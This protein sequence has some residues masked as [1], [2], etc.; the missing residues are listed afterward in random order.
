MVGYTSYLP[1][2]DGFLPHYLVFE[3]LAAAIHTVA[4][5][6]KSPRASLR[7][8]SGPKAPRPHPLTSHVYGVK[9]FYT[10]AI[11]LYA[12]YNITN[13]QLYDLA[14]ISFV[15]VLYLY[16]TEVFVYRTARIHEAIFPYVFAGTGVIWMMVQ[17]DWYLSS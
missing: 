5:Y 7:Q 4:C 17:R 14:V 10:S 16:I 15:G 9:N 1:Q 3:G 12:A 6:V 11:R 2:H 8:F 13:S